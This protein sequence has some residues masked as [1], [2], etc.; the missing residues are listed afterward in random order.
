MAFAQ[1]FGASL[2]VCG[3]KGPKGL[4]GDELRGAVAE[5]AEALKPH[6]EAAAGHD[7]TIGIE[8][9]GNA[10]IES[11]DSMK[12]L[13]EF[14]DSRHL[15]IALA[16]YH[17]PDDGDRMLYPSISPVNSFR[18]I[19]NHYLGA[20]FDLLEDRSYQPSQSTDFNEFTDVTNVVSRVAK[21]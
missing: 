2:L 16:P 14:T 17:L 18:F 21:N 15:G 7:V 5:F 12:W 20:D 19:F 3:S 9:H 13:V 11:P 1:E 8:N 4:A 10:L 6:I